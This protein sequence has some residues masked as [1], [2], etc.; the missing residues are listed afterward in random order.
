MWAST[1]R[2]S[3][4]E[5]GEDKNSSSRIVRCPYVFPVDAPQ[6]T[7]AAAPVTRSQLFLACVDPLNREHNGL[8][9]CPDPQLSFSLLCLFSRLAPSPSFL[10][11]MGL[12]SVFHKQ[13]CVFLLHYSDAIPISVS[14][15]SRTRRRRTMCFTKLSGQ[16]HLARYARDLLHRYPSQISTLSS[17]GQASRMEDT[18]AALGNPGASRRKG[19]PQ[20]TRQGPRIDRVRRDGRPQGTRPP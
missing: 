7:L 19:H 8:Q 10:L 15:P 13:V 6:N 5:G 2:C 20:E 14:S 4:V 11:A 9:R 1:R 18:S 17:S 16:G 12:E 3:A